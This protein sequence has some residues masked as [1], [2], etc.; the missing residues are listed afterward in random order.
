M[1]RHIDQ[2]DKKLD[3]LL[4]KTREA[5]QRVAEALSMKLSSHVSPWRQT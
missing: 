2:Q 5:N 3:E 4:E 1:K